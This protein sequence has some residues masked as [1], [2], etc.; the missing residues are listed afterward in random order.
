MIKG[1]NGKRFNY[2]MSAFFRLIGFVGCLI[3]FIVVK[4]AVRPSIEWLNY[5]LLGL[6]IGGLISGVFNLILCGFTA[7]AYKI[8]ICIQV[9]CLIVTILTGGIIGTVFTSVALGTKV[10]N[11]EVDNEKIFKIK[12]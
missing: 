8:N 7:S 4:I 11:D 9:V 2:F 1:A 5:L 3:A 10:L 6:S 12:K